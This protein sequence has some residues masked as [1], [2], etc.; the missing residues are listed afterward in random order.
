MAN[1]GNLG[2]KKVLETTTFGWFG[3]EL[4]TNPHLTDLVLM[5]FA[6]DAAAIDENSPE[7]LTFVKRQMRL[8]IH[9]EDFE[10]FWSLAIENSQDT[11][12]L[13]TVMKAIVESAAKRPTVLPS[14]SSD[15]QVLT[16]VTSPDVSSWRDTAVSPLSVADRETVAAMSGRP[17]L[18]SV[19]VEF[20][21][22][23]AT[24]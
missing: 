19:V 8:V 13:M 4:R 16:V 20:A 18:Q 2:T 9:Y 21:R 14:G 10:S 12:D 23:R 7:A 24:G 11:M 1:L 15:G 3:A 5:D 6:E 22:Q 17:D